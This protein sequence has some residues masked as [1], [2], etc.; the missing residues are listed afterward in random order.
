MSNSGFEEAPRR[1]HGHIVPRFAGLATFARLPYA[2]T[3]TGVDVAIFGVPF[4]GGTTFR[5]GARFGPQGIRQSSRLLR[6]YHYALDVQPFDDLSVVDYGDLAVVPFDIYDTYAAVEEQL[7]V[8]YAHD[9]F[10]L[11]LGGDHSVGLPLLRA[12]AR[13]HGSVSLVQFDSHPD[14]WE[15]LFGKEYSHATV[16]KRAIEEGLIDPHS[17]TQVGIRGTFPY[18][19]DLARTRAMGLTVVTAEEM[20]QRGIQEVAAEIRGRVGDRVYLSFDIDFVDPA[21]APG[22]GTPEVGGPSSRQ[23]LDFLRELKT[24]PLVAADLVEVAPAYDHAEITCMLAANVVQ[25]MLALLAWRRV[26]RLEEGEEKP[27]AVEDPVVS[28]RPQP[29]HRLKAEDVATD[30][31]HNRWAGE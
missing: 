15:K 8:I 12:C 3:L 2:Q 30:D 11:A 5:P 29:G 1:P 21:Y 22:T 25:E 19:D 20:F 18:R 23:V 31:Q 24:L 16:M 9:V 6:S 13:K 7:S 14:T 26:H 10:P 4:D 28:V 17:S 27:P